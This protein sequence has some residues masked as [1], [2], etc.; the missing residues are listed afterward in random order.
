MTIA[1]VSLWTFQPTLVCF[2]KFLSNMQGLRPCTLQRTDRYL[3]MFHQTLIVHVKQWKAVLAIMPQS[4][5]HV[6]A[7]PIRAM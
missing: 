3:A 7:G 1:S 6:K 2:G 5:L 4:H